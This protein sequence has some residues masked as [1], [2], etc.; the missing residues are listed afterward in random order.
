MPSG[1]VCTR[2]AC[3]H[4][5]DRPRAPPPARRRIAAAGWIQMRSKT[6]WRSSFPFYAVESN[7]A[8]QTEVTH[9][10]L[11]CQMRGHAGHD[12]LRDLLD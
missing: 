6:P 3:R 1:A 2:E 8:C 12:D 9:A 11:P 10:R 7:T 5:G 4:A